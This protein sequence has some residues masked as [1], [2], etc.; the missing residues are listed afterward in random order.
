MIRLSTKAS[1]LLESLESGRTKSCKYNGEVALPPKRN[2][3][4]KVIR[5][6]LCPLIVMVLCWFLIVNPEVLDKVFTKV[7]L[8]DQ[9]WLVSHS[10]A[11]LLPIVPKD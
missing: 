7:T 3:T 1:L 11:K 2:D 5:W 8:F 6:W 10:V 9:K 4:L